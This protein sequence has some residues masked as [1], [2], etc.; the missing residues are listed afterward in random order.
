MARVYQD[1][2]WDIF[3]YGHSN[4]MRQ[5]RALGSSLIVGVI[6]D[7]CIAEYKVP[8]VLTL[9]ERCELVQSVRW[10]DTVIPGVPHTMD[11]QFTR[12]MAEGYGVTMVVHGED[13]TIMPDGRDAYQGPKNA[14]IYWVVPRTA[15]ISTTELVRA[16]LNGTAVPPSPDP[17][18]VPAWEPRSSTVYVDGAFDCLHLG[19]IEFFKKARKY[20]KHLVVGLHSDDTV[21]ARRGRVPTLCMADRA[22]A[23]LDCKYVDGV[24]ADSPPL[25]TH[26]FLQLVGAACVA[27][28]S[29]HETAGADSHRYKRVS[30]VLVSIL[31]ASTM[32]LGTVRRRIVDNRETY[33]KKIALS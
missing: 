29:V 31:S 9:E 10:V 33:V 6:A 27:R 5:A 8:P 14:G 32:T 19:H 21:L 30:D 20:A 7:E 18:T 12:F 25:L 23:L 17:P 3:H 15:G 1:G 2:C 26:A 13:S 16:L 28:G 4:A 11:D 22:R 24:L